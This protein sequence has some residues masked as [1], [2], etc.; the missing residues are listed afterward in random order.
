VDYQMRTEL[1]RAHQQ[2]CGERVVDNKCS[3]G[4]AA[5]HGQTFDVAHAQQRIGDGFDQHAAGFVL[6]DGGFHSG[7]VAG[8]DVV[9][10]EAERCDTLSSMRI[11]AP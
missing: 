7:R 5:E 4:I 10:G 9:H 11:V 8:V 2:G 1:D 6:G 3:A